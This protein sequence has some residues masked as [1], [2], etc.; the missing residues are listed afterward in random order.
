MYS[1]ISEG[2]S[3]RK[4]ISFRYYICQAKLNVRNNSDEKNEK[5]FNMY[6]VAFF[7]FRK[8]SIRLT[9]IHINKTFV[10]YL[11]RSVKFFPHFIKS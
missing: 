11:Q 8:L 4:E 3:L 7:L 5:P 6:K 2:K 9:S 10:L 1:I